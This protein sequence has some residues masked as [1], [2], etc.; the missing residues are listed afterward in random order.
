M[1]LPWKNIRRF[2][3]KA[4]KQPLYALNVLDKRLDANLYYRYARGKA[5]FPEAI[6]FFLTHRC[7]LKCKMCGQWGESGVTK[8]QPADFVKSELSPE[9]IKSVINNVSFFKPGITLFG[10]EPLLYEKCTELIRYIKQ[11][12]MHCL[13]ISN[14]FML[15]DVAKDLVSA[16]LD[17][18]N[19]SL[20]GGRELHDSIRG[21]PGLFDKIMLGFDKL[22]Y[23]KN[24]DKKQKPLINLQCT[25]TKY[26]YK[27]LEQLLGVA[28]EI[29]ASSLTF[30]NLIFLNREVLQK[31]KEYDN[32]LG[33]TSLDWEGFDFN[34]EIDPEVLYGKIKEILSG[35]YNF[36]VDFYPNFSHKGLIEYYSNSSYLPSDY[37][38]RCLS[39]WLVAYIF[40]DGEVG[41]CLNSSFSYG[42]IKD[43]KF[44][45]L[46]NNAQAVKFRQALKKNKLFPVCARC[47]E[48]YRY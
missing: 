47:T 6:T 19:V 3:Y 16:G 17:E 18:L 44:T 46:W 42:N 4:T 22:N 29:K 23:Y 38:T 10:G 39:P 35:K 27:Y 20:D 8:K 21:L 14:G 48:L 24:L 33:C 12:R 5:G 30:H 36:A 32:L 31:Q 40:P 34:P 41:P 43:S 7:N 2:F 15:E 25:I 13:M 9:E 45:D 26:N 11:K 1:I 28:E 37:Q